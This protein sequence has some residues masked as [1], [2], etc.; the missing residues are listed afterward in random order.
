MKWL[1]LLTL[2]NLDHPIAYLAYEIEALCEAAGEEIKA[3]ANAKRSWI[4]YRCIDTGKPPV[5][6]MR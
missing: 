5:W 6:P 2:S 3:H 1:Q 4:D